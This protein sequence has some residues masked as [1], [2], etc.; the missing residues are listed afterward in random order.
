VGFA[1]GPVTAIAFVVLE[2]FVH[3]QP[4]AAWDS[5]YPALGH[6]CKNLAIN[7]RIFS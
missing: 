2:A 1:P 4:S 6:F 7:S 3:P 5:A